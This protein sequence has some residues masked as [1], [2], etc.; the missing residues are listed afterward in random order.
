MPGRPSLLPLYVLLLLVFSAPARAE[1]PYPKCG[2]PLAPSCT[3]PTDFASYLFLPPTV[4]PTVP[5]HAEPV[6]PRAPAPPPAPGGRAK[7]I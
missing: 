5:P 6:T 4:P 1:F 2:G 7:S 3:D